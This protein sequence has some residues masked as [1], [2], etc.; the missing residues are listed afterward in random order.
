MLLDPFRDKMRLLYDALATEKAYRHWIVEFL[1]FHPDG[2]EW[3]HPA[4][5][6]F[7]HFPIFPSPHHRH[8]RLGINPFLS[9]S[10]DH[11]GRS[12]RVAPFAA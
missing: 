10:C 9:A 8:V 2:S 4:A 7:A 3:R 12:P 6:S 1:R 11:G 5:P